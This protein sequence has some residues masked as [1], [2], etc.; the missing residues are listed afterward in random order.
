ML[1]EILTVSDANM[2][3]GKLMVSPI[4]T[5]GI[6]TNEPLITQQ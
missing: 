2:S 6:V 1:S 4:V 3:Y 5:L